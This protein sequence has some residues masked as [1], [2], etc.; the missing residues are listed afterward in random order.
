MFELV[1]IYKYNWKQLLLFD[2]ADG[3]WLNAPEVSEFSWLMP[4]GD[5]GQARPGDNTVVLL[6]LSLVQ[7]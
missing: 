3:W 6:S 2:K 1:K 7:V 4:G 5:A